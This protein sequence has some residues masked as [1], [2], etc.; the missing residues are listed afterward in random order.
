MELILSENQ[1]NLIKQSTKKK[2]ELE[3]Y[4]AAI[5]AGVNPETL[6]LIDGKFSWMPSTNSDTWKMSMER[7]LRDV[8]DVYENF[9]TL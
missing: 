4:T 8:L 3:L 2:L 6:E 1:K 9:L 7:H 5:T